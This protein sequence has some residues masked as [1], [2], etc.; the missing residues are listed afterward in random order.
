VAAKPITTP[1]TPRFEDCLRPSNVVKTDVA[2]SKHNVKTAGG[3][4]P[5]KSAWS[6]RRRFDLIAFAVIA[7]AGVAWGI[8]SWLGSQSE[9]RFD[10]LARSGKA[11]LA[12]V[13]SPPFEGTGHQGPY[14]YRDNPPTSGRHNPLPLDPGFFEVGQPPARLVHSLEHGHIV[15]YY[16]AAEQSDLDTLRVWTSLFTHLWGGVIATPKAG[17]GQSLILTARRTKLVLKSFADATAAAFIDR[18]RGRGPE[19]PI[20]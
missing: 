3:A 10:D 4:A 6:G 18:Y 8:S 14:S 20:R 7:I 15:I 11:S 9:S 2:K 17:L 19:N 13:E 1:S 12:A 5:A 16:D